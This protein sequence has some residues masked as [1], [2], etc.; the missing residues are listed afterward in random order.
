MRKL[1]TRCSTQWHGKKGTCLLYPDV[2]GLMSPD[3]YGQLYPDIYCL[4]STHIGYMLLV[5][6]QIFKMGNPDHG[7][8][9]KIKDM[10]IFYYL[11][12]YR[13]CHSFFSF[14]FYYIKAKSLLIFLFILLFLLSPEHI[15]AILSKTHRCYHLKSTSLL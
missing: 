4:M 15:V 10:K 3:V 1:H 2:Y 9:F 14:N 5:H 6:L 7:I 13:C 11:K 12:A 8:Y